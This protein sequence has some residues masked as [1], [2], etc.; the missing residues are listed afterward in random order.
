MT[1]LPLNGRRGHPGC[2]RPARLPAAISSFVGRGDDVA[3]VTALLRDHPLTTLTGP[4]GTGKTRLA[5]EVAR[6]SPDAVFVDLAR[7][8]SL[9]DETVAEAFGIRFD[10]GA[11]A[12]AVAAVLADEPVLVVLDNCEHLLDRCA[13]LATALLARAPGARILAT[14]RERLGVPGEQ[15]H[16]VAPLPLPRAARPLGGGA[17]EPGRAALRRPRRGHPARLR[18]HRRQR[19]RR[20]RDLPPPRRAAARRGAGRRADLGAAA[21]RAGRPARRRPAGGPHRGAAP[22]EPDGHRRVEPR[23]AARA[24]ARAVPAARRVPRRVRPGRGRG[25]RGGRPDA[26]AGRTSS[27]AASSR[28]RTGGSGSCRPPARSPGPRRPAARAGRPPS[29]PRP[30]LPRPRPPRAPPPAPR[31]LRALAR[32]PAPRARQPPRRAGVGGEPGRRAGGARRARRGPLAL[33]GRARLPRAKDCAG[34]ARRSRWSGPT[35]RNGWRCCPR[36]P[37]CTWVGPS[38]PRPRSWRARRASS[39]SAAATAGGRATR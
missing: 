15:V 13:E 30:P 24:R 27:S 26:A 34:W 11:L 18:D 39:P 8:A 33:L 21:A 37:S 22:P 29:P 7:T 17:G 16:P 23:P 4:G 3:R 6:G 36:P 35:V 12:D 19:G 10:G 31:G 28:P 32:R 38:S 2:Q 5:L 20:R 9:F 1:L 14:S 25:R